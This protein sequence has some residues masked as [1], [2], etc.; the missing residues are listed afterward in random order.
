MT[1]EFSII[2]YN[3]IIIHYI[4]FIMKKINKYIQYLAW[5]FFTVKIYNIKVQK[6]SSSL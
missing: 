1:P 2:I 3:I 6:L 5:K 4:I